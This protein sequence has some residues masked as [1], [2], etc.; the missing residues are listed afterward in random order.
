MKPIAI[1]LNESGFTKRWIEYC[2]KYSISYL[3]VNCYASNI[4]EILKNCSCLMWHWD[5]EN[6]MD[7]LFARQFLITLNLMS[8]KV[9]PDLYA[10]LHFDDK[11]G[12]KYLFE[13]I[14]APV[15]NS[16]V[17]YDR[18]GAMKWAQN[19]IYPKVFKLRNG[20]GSQNVQ[21]VYSSREANGIIN[22]A[23]TTGFK[24][25]NK[26]NVFKDRFTKYWRTKNR[27]NLIS[28]MK[29]LYKCF[30]PGYDEK[31]IPKEK[32]YVYF[33]DFL[34]GNSF[35]TRLIVIGHRCFGLRRYNRKRDFRASGSGLLDYDPE[36]IDKRAIKIAFDIAGKINSK[37]LA[38]DFLFDSDSNPLV[39]EMS[40]GF[41]FGDFT[42]NCKGYWDTALKWH[43]GNQNLQ[44]L[45][46]EDLLLSIKS[47]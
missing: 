13:S 39:I 7:R 28:L 1:H 2:K 4:I 16:Y 8:I 24:T 26:Y 12:Q 18:I 40:Y 34:S 29:I 44:Y 46:V 43:E 5:Y 14:N 11:I 21:L 27:Q 10:T 9:F 41:P 31:F 35:D 37:S 19:T 45:M 22:K 15:P 47:E 38:L 25:Q 36:K 32:G 33:Q 20:A 23:F 3:I 42:D 17:F 30:L 6:Y